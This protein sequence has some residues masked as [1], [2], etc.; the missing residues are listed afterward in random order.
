MLVENNKYKK[1]IEKLKQDVDIYMEME[2]ELAKQKVG[3][4]CGRRRKE[5]ILEKKYTVPV[6]EQPGIWSD[7]DLDSGDETVEEVDADDFRR[8][9]DKVRRY[10]KTCCRRRTAIKNAS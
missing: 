3:K 1:D 9:R 4:P 7:D 10:R 2:K 8:D 6:E 5:K